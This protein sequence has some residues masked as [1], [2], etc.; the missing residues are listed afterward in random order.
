M[1]KSKKNK[2]TFL[3]I[4]L[5]DNKIQCYKGRN[6]QEPEKWK[7]IIYYS[8]RKRHEVA[9]NNIIDEVVGCGQYQDD[10]FYKVASMSRKDAVWDYYRVLK[11]HPYQEIAVK[12]TNPKKYEDSVNRCV[13]THFPKDKP[14]VIS[15]S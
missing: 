5:P 10:T 9:G 14:C 2:H 3:K 15:F 8:S 13:I 7:K 11:K 4:Y 1:T 12:T 6:H